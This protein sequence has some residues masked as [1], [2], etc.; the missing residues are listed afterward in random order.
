MR[1]LLPLVLAA[2]LLTA[3]GVGPDKSREDAVDTTNVDKSPAH[4]VAFNNH[5]PNVS[6]KCDGA[7]HRVYVTTAGYGYIVVIDDESCR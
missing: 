3:C 1:V 5:Y 4:V 7:G 2:V 6:T